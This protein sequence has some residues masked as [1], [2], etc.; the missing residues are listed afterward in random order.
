MILKDNKKIHYYALTVLGK[1]RVGIVKKISGFLAENEIN[2][3][4]SSMTR[5]RNEFAMILLLASRQV[6]NK[7]FLEKLKLQTK[8]YELEFF[9]KTLKSEEI[10]TYNSQKPDRIFSIKV[11]G[12]DR[13]GIVAKISSALAS[14]KINIIDMRTHHIGNPD[15]IFK[16]KKSNF[17]KGIYILTIEALP[18]KKVNL[19]TLKKTLLKAA[20]SL[21]CNMSIDEYQPEEL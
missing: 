21:K 10:R 14:R 17:K 4:D 6:L 15:E 2:I 3:D 9:L 5:L 7:N 8:D 16:I 1:D 18:T 13:T 11:Y 20:R 19:A 12:A